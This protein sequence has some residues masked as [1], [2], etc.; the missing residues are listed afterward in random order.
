M[1]IN[2]YFRSRDKRNNSFENIFQA[3]IDRLPA[4]FEV[5]QIAAQRAVDWRTTLAARKE[6]AD[7][8]HITGAVNYLAMGLPGEKSILTV[9]DIGFYENQKNSTLKRWAYGLVWFK[10]PLKRVRVITVVSEF[11]R[12][13]LI[14]VFNVP[15]KK[16]RVIHNPVLPHFL[17][18]P[19][20]LPGEILNILHIGSGDHKNLRGLLLACRELPVHIIK[21]GILSEA[22]RQLIKTLG[23]SVEEHTGIANEKVAALY[24]R[25]DV[26]YFASLYEGFGMPIVEAQ[27]TGRPVI[28]SN[29]GAMKEVAKDGAILVDPL[30]HDEIRGAIVRLS[31]DSNYYQQ[32][33]ERGRLNAQQYSLDHTVSSYVALYREF[34]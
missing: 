23:T 15:E 13:K 29:F 22:E 11:T 30:K 33:S 25:A 28:T 21:V 5:K 26:L 24:G 1:K 17:P 20:R 4:D 27:V 34:K 6:V 9:H 18:Q 10:L 7:V 32:V 2:Y 12:Q 31:R 3:V 19:L 14:D 16:V 8:H